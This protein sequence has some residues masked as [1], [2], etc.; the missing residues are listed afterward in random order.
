[1]VSH[2]VAS[3]TAEVEQ[4]LKSWLRGRGY[5]IKSGTLEVFPSGNALRLPLQRGF[6]WLSENGTIRERREDLTKDEAI[7]SFLSDIEE[8]KANWKQAKNLINS[9][10]SDTLEVA[11]EHQE[12]LNT[13]GL[14]G[15]F[16]RG[17]DWEKYQRGR[18][19]WTEGLSTFSSNTLGRRRATQRHKRLGASCR[20]R[21]PQV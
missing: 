9:Q 4:T 5:E 11:Q 6:A 14:E 21:I 7:G 16:Q 12:R 10:A 17:I 2:L 18:K 1:M 3:L 8:H 19:Y 15:L 20:L 13:E